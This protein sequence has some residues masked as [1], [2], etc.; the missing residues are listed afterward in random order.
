MPLE[1]NNADLIIIKSRLQTIEGL[2]NEIIN[3]MGDSIKVTGVREIVLRKQNPGLTPRFLK[4]VR[5][6]HSIGKRLG[7]DII[8][9]EKDIQIILAEIDEEN[10]IKIEATKKKNKKTK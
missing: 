2:L 1:N 3:K 4:N 5:E 7:R 9:N 10:R 8:Y 6:K